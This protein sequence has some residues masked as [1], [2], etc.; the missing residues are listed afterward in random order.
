MQKAI[1]RKLEILSPRI[2]HSKSLLAIVN[3]Y[4]LA[5]KKAINLACE[6]LENITKFHSIFILHGDQII[7]SHTVVSKWK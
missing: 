1:N 6:N 4:G 3:T 2:D 7:V 5:D